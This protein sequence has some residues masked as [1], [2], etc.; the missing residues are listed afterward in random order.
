MWRPIWSCFRWSLPCNELLL[1]V[2]C[3]LTAPF[4]PYLYTTTRKYG[5]SAVFSLLHLSWACA[6]QALPGTLLYEARTFLPLV[7]L[8]KDVNVS[9]PKDLN[10]SLPKDINKAAT[11]QSAPRADCIE[12]QEQCL[13]RSQICSQWKVDWRRIIHIIAFYR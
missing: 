8:P 2:R 9:L 4:Q 10:V 3:A 7:S 1:V 5:P 12:F 6:P 13:A 11:T